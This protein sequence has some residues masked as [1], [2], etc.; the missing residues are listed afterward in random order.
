MSPRSTRQSNSAASM[1]N[2]RSKRA[3]KGGIGQAGLRR[4]KRVALAAKTNVAISKSTRKVT[5]AKRANRQS[6]KAVAKPNS[7][8]LAGTRN[9]ANNININ[10]T[11]KDDEKVVSVKKTAQSSTLAATKDDVPAHKLLTQQVL[12]YI[13]SFLSESHL[14]AMSMTC[15]YWHD[16]LGGGS[17]NFWRNVAQRM[18]WYTVQD[19]C[20]KEV[21]AGKSFRQVAVEHYAAIKRALVIKT[22][23]EA[24][25]NDLPES[26][27]NIPPPP[28]HV[29]DAEYYTPVVWAD[30]QIL[31]A[32]GDSDSFLRLFEYKHSP[33]MF[34]KERKEIA[35][36]TIKN[37]YPDE[38]VWHSSIDV[39]LDKEYIACMNIRNYNLFYFDKCHANPSKFVT[40]RRSDFLK[41]CAHTRADKKET[42][43][44]EFWTDTSICRSLYEYMKE[45]D[46]F[47]DILE[48]CHL[49]ASLSSAI[50][51]IEVDTWA[52]IHSCGKG[53]FASLLNLHMYYDNGYGDEKRCPFHG[54]LTI[55]S[56]ESNSVV[57]V[58][59][60][61]SMLDNPGVLSGVPSLK[62]KAV[63]DSAVAVIRSRYHL[64]T[65]LV[66]IPS[67]TINKGGN[68]E[69]INVE[70]KYS[71]Y[72][73]VAMIKDPIAI[74]DDCIVCI[75]GRSGR[76]AV[77]HSTS[78][79]GEL[80]DGQEEE[81]YEKN[82]KKRVF[83]EWV[84][85]S[86][87]RHSSRERVATHR[88]KATTRGFKVCQAFA[89]GREHVGLF[90][91]HGTSPMNEVRGSISI[92]RE[93]MYGLFVIHAKTGK[94]ICH[95][96]LD[97]D[98]DELAYRKSFIV[99]DKGTLVVNL[100]NGMSAASS[101][102]MRG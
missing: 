21:Y 2:T 72:H 88:F 25:I 84:S 39:A 59:R 58:G 46:G 44:S 26:G 7:Q 24:L 96:D 82:K 56:A 11:N 9:K 27:G 15:K 53:M 77:R 49:C 64:S 28:S 92:E 86:F 75:D 30:K 31:C 5:T 100:Q 6:Q 47:S 55:F 60:C 16:E 63:G 35:R 4:S 76:K 32:Y 57:W 66:Y 17:D 98:K 3:S 1:P 81:D 102:D 20:G 68:I 97:V 80:G 33:E 19:L 85:L 51:A 40:M 65:L 67:T 43:K 38:V 69:V 52:G 12:E 91:H 22:A 74:L 78:G 61:N 45:H 37:F 73:D 36:L 93:L 34:S 42:N 87:Y 14:A 89:L 18:E 54:L 29:V 83:V 95:Y 70:P 101:R 50:D 62:V 48:S 90:C 13:L 41:Y 10:E 79:T 71:G 94:E 99:T 23:Y 8:A